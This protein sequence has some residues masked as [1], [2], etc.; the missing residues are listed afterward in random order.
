[1][2]PILIHEEAR[3]LKRKLEYPNICMNKWL[4]CIEA[5]QLSCSRATSSGSS[6]QA[7]PRSMECEAQGL[8][9]TARNKRVTKYATMA[10][11]F[12]LGVV[13]GMTGLNFSHG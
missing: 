4:E 9:Q 12:A 11:V 7:P 1:M 5:F 8:D 10:S 13:L 3:Q 6:M 2:L